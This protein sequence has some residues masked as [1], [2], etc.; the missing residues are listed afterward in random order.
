MLKQ[1]IITVLWL[2]P[3]VIGAIFFLPAEYFAW[4]LVPVFMIGAKE[5]GSFIDPECK[6]TQWTFTVTVTVILL[7]LNFIVP[8]DAM[9]LKGQLHP[10]F[11]S[12][13]AIGAFWWF[14][15]AL[16]VISF[17]KTDSIWKNSPMLK[18]MFGQLTL[19]PCFVALITLKSISSN[20]DPYFGG[21]LVFL[22][23][24]VV[25]AADTGAYFAGRAFGK[26]KLMPNVSPNKTLE[27][28]IGGLLATLVVACGVMYYSPEQELALVITVTLITAL[29]SAFGD[30]SES[31]FKRAADI[32]DSGTILPGHGGVLDR[33]DSLTAALPIFTLIYIAF[34]I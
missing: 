11:V 4:V 8:V 34:W 23:M 25:W 13:I 19:I 10:I 7:A 15:S 26:H 33:M 31:M 17:P 9:W 12:I 30:L 6:V 22:V 28:L 1:R 3:L 21:T 27:G 32:K 14:L 2:L 18:S 5:W 29:A 20:V 24:L 16:L